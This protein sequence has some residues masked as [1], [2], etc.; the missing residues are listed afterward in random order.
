MNNSL[1]ACV[2]TACLL[3]AVLLGV[4]I[5]G[6]PGDLRLAKKYIQAA[7]EI[8]SFEAP[9][10]DYMDLLLKSVV[11]YDHQGIAETDW[12]A[13]PPVYK[14]ET[15][16]L[17][18]ERGEKG[19]GEKMLAMMSKAL[20][21][22]Y[23][24]VRKSETFRPLLA[25]ET[26][27]RLEFAEISLV[28]AERNRPSLTMEARQLA[29][30]ISRVCISG[31]ESL[32]AL[33][34][35]FGME[36]A[37]ARDLLIERSPRD[38][39]ERAFQ[40]IGDP[41]KLDVA[42]RSFVQEADGEWLGFRKNATFDPWRPKGDASFDAPPSAP[43]NVV[44]IKLNPR[45]PSSG[46]GPGTGASPTKPKDPRTPSSGGTGWATEGS[47]FRSSGFQYFEPSPSADSNPV[48]DAL[49]QAFGEAIGEAFNRPRS[50]QAQQ[51]AAKP[52]DKQIESAYGQKSMPP[53]KNATRNPKGLGGIIL[54]SAIYDETGFSP[55]DLR[56]E[57]S[58]DSGEF[59][60]TS[61]DQRLVFSPVQREHAVLAYRLYFREGSQLTGSPDDPAIGL[62]GAAPHRWI[63]VKEENGVE[64]G[65]SQ[66]IPLV[67]N[68]DVADLE[69]SM[70]LAFADTFPAFF[71]DAFAD[72]VEHS[73]VLQK[74]ARL[75][76]NDPDVLERCVAKPIEQT[77]GWKISDVDLRLTRKG[78]SLV[79]SPAKGFEQQHSD[80]LPTSLL[81]MYTFQHKFDTKMRRLLVPSEGFETKGGLQLLP[82][83]VASQ[84]S[85]QRLQSLAAA[86]AVARW[87][88]RS[89]ATMEAIT[90]AKTFEPLA[91][92]VMRTDGV[93]YFTRDDFESSVESNLR[94][95]YVYADN[96]KC[97]SL[98]RKIETMRFTQKLKA[99]EIKA[100]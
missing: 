51:R 44:R 21:Q 11:G 28:D 20:A 61:G 62:L 67:V 88:R 52:F 54:G 10:V 57:P 100:K 14:L 25:V 50:E 9:S 53:F 43:G 49:G 4:A 47:G 23:A 31:H 84:P 74:L 77:N 46:E 26:P 99:G 70:D 60:I 91:A 64:K 95:T 45:D 6:A 98:K 58:G 37:L 24:S 12:I 36:P 78:G 22:E 76:G 3:F 92:M 68:P 85:Y 71:R 41:G 69:V 17:A 30:E 86:L 93:E 16:Y 8:A 82:Y 55:T 73:R 2:A 39:F 87:A 63:K 66:V 97:A 65:I 1:K 5:Y 15:A 83:L 81:T 59:V 72:S 79:L 7:D 75:S 34:N 42:L 38:V 56:W 27:E 18:A 13:L 33:I 35:H 40:E 29:R 19:G 48:G 94:A 90:P 80:L 89:S 32:S 96:E